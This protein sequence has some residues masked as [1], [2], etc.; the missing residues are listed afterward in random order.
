VRRVRGVLVVA[1]ATLGLVACSSGASTV[2]AP[3]KDDRAYPV[4]ADG[5]ARSILL[6][7][8]GA[9]VRGIDVK[10]VKATDARLNGPYRQLQIADARSDNRRKLKQKAPAAVARM[11]L[12]VPAQN[13]WPR[14]FLA[15][16]NSKDESTPLLQVLTSKSAR[17]PYGLWAQPAM[18]PGATL[19]P[20]AS[21]TT[22]TPVVPMDD[23]S[24]VM[25]P[26]DVLAA[27]A[28]YLNE[29]GRSKDS[30]N[31]RRSTYSDQLIGR[32][33]ADRK[34]L[35]KVATLSSKHDPASETT[36]AVRTADGGALVIGALRQTL[37]VKVK[38]GTGT[39]T[40]T[41][42]ELAGLAKG[43]KSFSKSFTRVALE[44]L[45]FTVPPKNGGPISVVAAQKGDISASAR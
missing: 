16:G 26:K 32:L 24:L 39:V 3:P 15:V 29:S 41:D 43:K 33:A 23:G 25:Q 27:Y 18:L 21:V 5:Q 6:A 11:R 19:P 28:G 7:I 45:V 22:G 8:D 1:A 12:V 34:A 4:V 31:F 9:L 20:T 14:F 30:K 17:S 2:P 44:V 10:D 42:P 40:L 36:F 35:K 13:S 37:T 38:K